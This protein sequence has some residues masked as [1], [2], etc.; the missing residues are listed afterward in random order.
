M[1]VSEFLIHPEYE[2]LLILYR[3]IFV[4]EAL[5]K[6]RFSREFQEAAAAIRLDEM[7]IKK[8]G[9]KEGGNARISGS[10]KAIVARVIKDQKPH[11]GYAFMPLS[12]WSNSLMH[13]NGENFAAMRVAKVKISHTTLPV[14]GLQE[15]L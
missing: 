3:D 13:F 7:D 6:N 5:L 14:T 11:Q 15:L 8:I 9:L 2:I 10:S 12:P 4:D 1:P